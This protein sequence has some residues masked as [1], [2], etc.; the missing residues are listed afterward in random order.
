[1]LID[2]Y[3]DLNDINMLFYIWRGADGIMKGMRVGLML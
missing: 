1:M 2:D 3:L